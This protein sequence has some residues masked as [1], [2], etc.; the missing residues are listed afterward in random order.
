[1]LIGSPLTALA[2]WL[3]CGLDWPI[4]FMEDQF[5]VKERLA[6]IL[7][8]FRVVHFIAIFSEKKVARLSHQG[9]QLRTFVAGD[10]I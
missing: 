4:F 10:K 6:D 1:M 5:S 3:S 9:K 7:W 8:L 2:V